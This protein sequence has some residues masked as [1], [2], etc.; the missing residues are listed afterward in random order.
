[1]SSTH[2]N[3]QTFCFCQSIEYS[4]ADTSQ[5]AQ[6]PS[7]GLLATS[8]IAEEEAD[9]ESSPSPLNLEVPSSKQRP[10]FHAED[11][12]Q[13]QQTVVVTQ[14]NVDVGN[15]FDMGNS[16]NVDMP[17]VDVQSHVAISQEE[18]DHLE[19]DNP[20]EAFDFLMKCDAL[21]SK[22]NEKSPNV[23][24]NDP[25]ESSRDSLWQNFEAKFWA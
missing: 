16:S 22:S 18:L 17:V 5:Q 14:C 20:L 21:F 12:G 4:H 15:A 8:T 23:S 1:M 3:T 11:L 25:S 6:I 2:V 7:A 13:D 19:R 10:T 9:V 24:V